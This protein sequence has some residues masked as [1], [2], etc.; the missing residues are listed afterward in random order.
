MNKD[1]SIDCLGTLI[2]IGGVAPIY[3]I[4]NLDD[5]INLYW[6]GTLINLFSLFY[7]YLIIWSSP[8]NKFK[9]LNIQKLIFLKNISIIMV[10]YFVFVIYKIANAPILFVSNKGVDYA[11]YS[12]FI[13]F[14][15]Y[16]FFLI[17]L[18]YKIL[19]QK[20]NISKDTDRKN[21]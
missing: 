20:Q 8:K 2:L 17:N 15:C 5:Y 10:L 19:I 9:S 13:F 14:F 1:N 4:V 21:E 12:Y 16:L 6:K 7:I 3:L 11:I 18:I